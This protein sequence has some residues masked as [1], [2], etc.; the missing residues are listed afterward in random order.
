MDDYKSKINRCK[1]LGAEK[2]QKVVLKVENLKY[3]TIKFVC[4][5]FLNFYD[6]I[7]DHKKR[8][9]IKKVHSDVNKNMINEKYRRHKMLV[10][11]E[12]NCEKNINY[13][14]D[15][16]HPSNFIYYLNWNKQIHKRGLI[17][18]VFLISCFCVLSFLNVSFAS[19]L[20]LLEI[21]GAFINF[22]CVN[23]QNYNIYRF[24]QNE[25]KLKR[26]EKISQERNLKKYGEASRVINKCMTKTDN[27]PSS[28]DIVNNVENIEQLQQLRAMII[29]AKRDRSKNIKGKS[30]IKK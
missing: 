17:K 3:K 15:V 12:F 9:E 21:G 7:C 14:M 22:Q 8:R 13:H 30:Y 11:K 25:E 24:K 20:M 5:N 10:H 16:N 26:V 18:N 28:D 27:L 19:L 1:L 6:K 23:I 4:P 29:A 2:F